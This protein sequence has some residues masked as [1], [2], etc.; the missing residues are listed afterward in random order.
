MTD[1]IPFIAGNWK[2]NLNLTE[3]ASLVKTIRE[4]IVD[5]QGV[6][7]L[8]APPFT[9]LSVVRAAMGDA[10]IFLGAQNMHWEA[11]GAYTGE[12]SAAMLLEA[13]CT[14]VILGHSE[15]RSHFQEDNETIDLKVSA[16]VRRG[17]A[18]IVCIGETLE[19]REKGSTFRVITNQL[20]GSLK[21]LLMGKKMPLSTILAYEP[22]W[23]IGTGR[24]ATPQ[25]AQEVHHFIREWVKGA[26][27]GE[28]AGLLRI[29]YGGSV[30]PD[31]IKDLMSMPDIDGA[32]VGG[33][34]LKAESFIPII[35]FFGGGSPKK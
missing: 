1:R 31:N 25:Q 30:K 21:N 17:L 7:I 8:V 22:V 27:D 23:A 35:R 4:S 29:L 18:P 12:I 15:R 24:T 10:R 34:S 6:H 28:T 20:E 33:A 5:M 2:M 26:F 13:G 9:A 11:E 16:A 19:E 14:H 32:L 3:S